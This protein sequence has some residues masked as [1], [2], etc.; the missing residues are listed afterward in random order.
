MI[1]SKNINKKSL[2]F[3]LKGRLNRNVILVFLY[4]KNIA[5]PAIVI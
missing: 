2:I 3:L 5:N 1:K 4:N